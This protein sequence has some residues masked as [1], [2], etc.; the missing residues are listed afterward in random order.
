MKG[1]E[2]CRKYPEKVFAAG[3]AVQQRLLIPAAEVGQGKIFFGEKPGQNY[4]LK[5]T[6]WRSPNVVKVGSATMVSGKGFAKYV[7]HGAIWAGVN[8]QLC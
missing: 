7:V 8:F 5:E 3:L 6:E 1:Q 4:S 2:V